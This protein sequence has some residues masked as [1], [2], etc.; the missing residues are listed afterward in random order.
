MANQ[1]FHCGQAS[2]TTLV[3]SLYTR[4]DE[5][6]NLES[7]LEKQGRIFFDQDSVTFDSYV[8]CLCDVVNNE[9]IPNSEAKT[10][11]VDILLAMQTDQT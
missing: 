10:A 9:K 6:E 3:T 1:F 7:Y 8:N 11:A 2:Q 5:M 4:A